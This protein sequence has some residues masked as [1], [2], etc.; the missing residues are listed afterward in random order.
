MISLEVILQFNLVQET[1]TKERVTKKPHRK[2]PNEVQ[3][4]LGR[5][6]FESL[7]ESAPI[8]RTKRLHKWDPHPAYAHTFTWVSACSFIHSFIHLVTPIGAE[9]LEAV[10][11]SLVELKLRIE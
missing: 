4:R 9:G 7:V 5:R 1:R 2:I 3:Q 6:L 10:R 8:V 11:H